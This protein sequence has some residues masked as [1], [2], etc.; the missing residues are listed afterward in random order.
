MQIN[1]KVVTDHGPGVVV[2]WEA[3]DKEGNSIE[4]S[5]EDNGNRVAVKLDDGHSWCFDGLY[6]DR[7]AALKKV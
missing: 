2:G 5:T 3:F 1:D 6:Y 4:L 7:E